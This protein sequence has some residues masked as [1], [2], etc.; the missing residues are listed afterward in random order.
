MGSDAWHLQC[1]WRVIAMIYR[2]DH[3]VSRA[4]KEQDLSQVWSQAD[5]T[6][7]RRAQLNLC[8]SII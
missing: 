8:V 1:R 4:D 7:G 2:A 5:D 6:L 3:P